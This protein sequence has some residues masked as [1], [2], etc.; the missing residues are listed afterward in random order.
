MIDADVAV[1]GVLRNIQLKTRWQTIP[2][3][4]ELNDVHPD[5]SRLGRHSTPRQQV[6]KQPYDPSKNSP[7]SPQLLAHC[8]RSH[9]TVD[10]DMTR[11]HEDGQ[12]EIQLRKNEA[13]QSCC[14][15]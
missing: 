14:S 11:T 7:W 1:V 12:M 9:G 13:P 4:H 5:E 15:H 2:D 3:G 10:Q 8:R 6:R